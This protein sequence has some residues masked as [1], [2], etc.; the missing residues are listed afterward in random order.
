MCLWSDSSLFGQIDSMSIDSVYITS[1]RIRS[2]SIG[3]ISRQWK[4]NELPK[5]QYSIAELLRA[6]E[7]VFIKN[8]GVGTLATSS[9]RG[10]SAGHTAILWNG[11][12]IQSPML[13]LLDLSLLPISGMDE[14]EFTKGGSGATWG[15][16][17]IGGVIHFKNTLPIQ[18]GRNWKWKSILGSFGFHQHTASFSYGKKKFQ[19]SSHVSYQKANND[20]PYFIGNPKVKKNQQNALTDQLNIL[21]NLQWRLSNNQLF[22]IHFWFQNA[23]RQIP[24]LTTQNLSGA[25]QKDRSIR[26]VMHYSK[27]WKKSQL[28]IKGAIF[29]E[30][31]VY[32]DTLLNFVAPNQFWTAALDSYWK[33]NLGLSQTMLIGV[34]QYY[35][36]ATSNGYSDPRQEYK[37]AP[38]LFWKYSGD[39]LLAE[40]SVRQTFVDFNRV[41]IVPMLGL[42]Y[43]LLPWW[44]VK[45][46]VSR[47][48]RLP[49]FNDRFWEPGGNPDLHPE[50]GWSQEC[51]QLFNWGKN[52]KSVQLSISAFNRIIQD[53]ILWTP[54]PDLGYWSASNIAKVWSRGLETR[55]QCNWQVNKSSYR[56]SGGYDYVRSTNQVA[57]TLPKLALGSQLLYTPKHQGF[58]DFQ[59]SYS[60]YSVA[61]HH[62][63]TGAVSGVNK[64]LSDYQVGD[65]RMQ[66]TKI[67]KA[68]YTSSFFIKFNN[69]WDAEY[70]VVERRP[71][72][73]RHMQ[74]GIELQF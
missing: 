64:P 54:D 30:N 3:S 24:P 55:L 71:M 68:K 19:S 51:S 33:K 52:N 39:Q 5:I 15:S 44:N 45:L 29:T 32:S 26:A 7:G 17:A 9:I 53:W 12:P 40:I 58:A 60:S 16:G 11:I 74:A 20:F 8:Y 50:S 31:M 72:P 14:V 56:L 66:Y 4:T 67:W 63:F 25:S 2:Q 10:G 18:N 35:T 6:H 61:Y 38:Y 23:Y 43:R 46:K 1:S 49:T 27:G 73:G 57:L 69:I 34:N 59:Y 62:Q 37:L 42:E 36:Q 28:H 22:S 65:L 48:Y 21:Q 13:G 47:N 41:P 70:R